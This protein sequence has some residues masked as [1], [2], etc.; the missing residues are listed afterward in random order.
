MLE[1]REGYLWL[2]TGKGLLRFDGVGFTSFTTQNTPGMLGDRISFGTLWEDPKGVVWAGTDFSG[3]L[4]NDHGHWQTYQEKQGLFGGKVLR[5]DGDENG[6]TWIYT[7]AGVNAWTDGRLG[8]AIP[9]GGDRSSGTVVPYSRQ[10]T[11][12]FAKAG[13]WRHGRNGLERFAYG[14]WSSFPTPA[15]QRPFEDD[16]R[17]IFEDRSRRVW[18][19]MFSYPTTVFCAEQ[20]RLSHY[21]GLPP[22]ALVSYED[23]DGYLW[24]TDHS[25]HTSLWK[26]G[27]LFPLPELKAPF[28]LQVLETRNGALWAGTAGTDLFQFRRNSFGIMPTA[29]TPEIASV[30]LQQQG[31]QVWAGGTRVLHRS[32]GSRKAA[33]DPVQAPNQPP[34]WIQIKTLAK[35]ARGDLLIGSRGLDGVEELTP[36]G[37]QHI[38]LVPGMVQAMLSTRTAET[39]IGATSGLY[40]MTG[41]VVQRVSTLPVRSLLQT[42]AGVLLAGTESGPLLFRDG[43]Q[44][45]GLAAW[46]YGPIVAM[47]QDRSGAV[48]IA[49]QDHGLVRFADDAL[50][51]LGT[52]D[53][54]PTDVLYSLE[55][56]DAGDLWM[57]SDVGLMRVRGRSIERKL[58]DT[59]G[60]LQVT[61]F[62]AADGLPASIFDPLG[63]QGALRRPNGELWFGTE[64]GVAVIRPSTLRT[65]SPDTHP[66][67]EEHEVDQSGPLPQDHIELRPGQTNLQIHYSALGS[68]NPE[69][70][71]FRYRL[72]PYDRDWVYARSRRVAYYSHLSPGRY[73]FQVQAAD[74]DG[75]GWAGGTA[76]T[77]VRVLTPFYRSWWVLLL[78]L[79]SIGSFLVYQVALRRR[80]HLADQRNRRL[81]THR[82][83]TTQEGE[84][85]RIAHELHDSIGQHLVLIRTLAMLPP[86]SSTTSGG[87]L[88]S[89][90]EQ[91]AVAIKEV[92]TI[93]Y[94]LRPYQL[95]RLGLT[96][97]VLSLIQSLERSSTVRVQ[98]SV[99][100][101]D[102]F[103]PKETE[104]NFYRIV[105]EALGNVLRH[106][107]ATS[108]SFTIIRTEHSL[109]LVLEDDG[110]GFPAVAEGKG[111]A[112][113]LVGMHERAEAL[114][115]RASIMSVPGQGTTVTIEA[116][117]TPQAR[118][119][120]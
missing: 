107:E 35:D 45:H 109:R 58:Q 24:L 111:S 115:G 95:D 100:N 26:D 94:D 63:D 17:E 51:A 19:S 76:T 66:V 54:L 70:L 117:Q 81:F 31:G 12:D 73:T 57:G 1:T 105:Q 42:S 27:R 86:G 93:S 83:L 13:L 49:T 64:Q 110:K 60:R 80:R 89:I 29:G 52:A 14:H 9:G 11:V 10:R 7:E 20:G 48:W 116:T 59:A 90:A 91:A 87:H 61:I 3:V 39:W 46:S 97:A 65:L 41:P 106:A 47:R 5:I 43:R 53:G 62:D 2:G 67:I 104:I 22:D 16:V 77:Y 68:N 96:K 118:M 84:R 15:L 36:R 34:Q 25:A 23:R 74:P 40:R 85:K 38:S 75:E 114:H 50:H 44:D 103:F 21:E 37:F 101:I 98:C 32:S 8:R 92:E 119:T 88:A 69:Q 82:L 79:L 71:V 102:N 120:P 18:Y 28:L 78:V 99:D 113:G 72:Q 56:D 4:R 108:V 6:I 30:L 55:F 112:L 33:F